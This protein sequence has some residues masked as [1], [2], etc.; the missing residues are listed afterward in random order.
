[1]LSIHSVDMERAKAK[2]R[3]SVD[4][5]ITNTVGVADAGKSRLRAFMAKNEVSQEYRQALQNFI[6]RLS[7]HQAKSLAKEGTG[8]ESAV[9]AFI[10][11]GRKFDKVMLAKIERGSTKAAMEVRYFVRRADGH[12][13]GA[14]SP[15]APNETRFFGTI[16]NASKWD[17]SG[18]YGS[19]ISDESVVEGERGYGDVKHYKLKSA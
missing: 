10:E 12:I 13:F 5:D 17:W 9:G 3:V 1:M 16:Y 4:Q 19:P 18:F 11:T 7:K 14:K 15:V 6:D 8:E 2:R